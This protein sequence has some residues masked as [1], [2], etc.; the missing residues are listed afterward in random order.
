MRESQECESCRLSLR[1]PFPVCSGEP[2]E[3]DQLRLFRIGDSIFHCQFYPRF[4]AGMWSLWRVHDVFEEGT[5]LDAKGLPVSGTWN[6]ALPDGEIA[7]GTPIPG[8][9]PLPTL[10]RALACNV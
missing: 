2:S 5:V 9:V 7:A 3:L 8:L 4:A 10:V 1:T 6:R